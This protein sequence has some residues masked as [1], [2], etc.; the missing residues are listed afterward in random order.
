VAGCIACK[1]PVEVGA[2]RRYVTLKKPGGG[3]LGTLP[4]AVEVARANISFGTAGE[5]DAWAKA[6]KPYL[7]TELLFQPVDDPWAL[8][9]NRGYAF[10]LVGVRVSQRCTGEVVFSQPPSKG[11]APRENC[12]AVA[13]AAEAP[14]KAEPAAAGTPE[15]SPP[16]INQAM[17]AVKPDIDSCLKHFP[18]RGTS[19]LSFVV[20]GS[21]QP[22]TVTVEGPAAGTALAQCLVDA[23]VRAKFPSFQRDT[24]R[25]KYPVVPPK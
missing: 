8:G 23:G 1:Q 22:Q 24:Q 25:F 15:L 12:T 11:P 17:A 10:R 13:A 20:A 9:P 3:T 6:V 18:T 5:A 19:F 16:A 14:G 7:R 4:A 2:E 21:G